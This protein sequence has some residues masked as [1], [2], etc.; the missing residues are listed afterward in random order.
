MRTVVTVA[1]IGVVA[2]L[3]GIALALDL[4]R[5]PSPRVYRSE[6]VRTGPPHAVKASMPLIPPRFTVVR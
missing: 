1:L 2:R 6:P 3:A 5:S 4:T